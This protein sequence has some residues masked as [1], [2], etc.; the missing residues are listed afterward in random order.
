MTIAAEAAVEGA[1]V[2]AKTICTTL[3]A[4]V[5]MTSLTKIIVA[6]INQTKTEK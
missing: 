5:G 6:K 4:V 3:V 2:I 1:N